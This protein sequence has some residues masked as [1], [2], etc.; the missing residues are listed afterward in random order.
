MTVL[1]SPGRGQP[2]TL[3]GDLASH[4]AVRRRLGEPKYEE[5]ERHLN[6][7]IDNDEIHTSSWMPGPNWN[8]TPLLEIYEVCGQDAELA[9]K[10]FRVIL[11]EVFETRPETWSFTHTDWARGLTCFQ[12]QGAP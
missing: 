11:W 1:V 3:R 5:I 4:V 6:D 2:V 7:L 12:V 8:G 10:N 9:A